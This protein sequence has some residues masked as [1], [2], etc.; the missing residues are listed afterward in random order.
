MVRA[1][2]DEIQKIERDFVELAQL[3]HDLDAIVVQQEVPVTQIEQGAT[4]AHENVNKGN[5]QMDGAIKSARS[6]R[7][8]KWWC[9]LITR[10]YSPMFRPM[11]VLTLMFL[12]LS[13]LLS[14]VLWSGL[15]LRL[16][17]TTAAAAEAAIN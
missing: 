4:D 2:H 10:E 14:S 9:L 15:S 12:Q 11:V 8:K 13:S 7:R 16:L 17:A 6:A 3:F 1:R 5:E